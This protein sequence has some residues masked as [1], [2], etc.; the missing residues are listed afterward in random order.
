VAPATPAD[1]KGLLKAAI[2]DDNPVVFMEHKLL[3]GCQGE[4]PEQDDT[5]IPLGKARLARTGTDI[6]LIAW[7]W[8]TVEAERAAEDLQA[9]GISAEVVDL[10]SLIPLDIETVIASVKRTHRVLIV[11]EAPRTGGFGAEVAC[12][13]FERI[14]DYLDAPI[15]RLATP[16]VP[17]S[18]SP[19]LERTAMPDRHRIAQA[20]MGMVNG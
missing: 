8:M 9:H 15:R 20:A 4:V 12:R 17:F 14:Y 5:L 11:Q 6:T 13:I 16:D 10:R 1:A 19:P 7:S 2:R 18:A 3:Y